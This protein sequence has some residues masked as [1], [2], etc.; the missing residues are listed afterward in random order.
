VLDELVEPGRE[1]RW[2][3]QEEGEAR[4]RL[5][6]EPGEKAPRDRRSA[7][8]RAG[9]EGQA[10]PK[11]DHQSVLPGRRLDPTTALAD[12]VRDPKEQTEHDESCGYDIARAEI[13][14]DLPL[15]GQADQGHGEGADQD[16]PTEPGF[17]GVPSRR[18]L[19]GSDP[20]RED[21]DEVGP[22]V[23]EQ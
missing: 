14:V 19:P 5:P 12:E 1:H 9:N 3:R 8:A 11:A 4:R 16:R 10:L 2:D 17:W 15:K 23:D 6:V 20:T 22:E 21:A 13:A 18:I 7:P